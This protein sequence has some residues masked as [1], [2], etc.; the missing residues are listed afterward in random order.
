LDLAS[1]IQGFRHLKIAGNRDF[2][3]QAGILYR[4]LQYRD[5]CDC[6]TARLS[7]TGHF[8]SARRKYNRWM[9]PSGRR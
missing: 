2:G 7:S 1:P 8:V 5:I 9:G 6:G 4:H 3:I